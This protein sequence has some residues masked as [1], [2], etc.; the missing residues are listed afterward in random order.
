M[1][2]HAITCKD[3]ENCLPDFSHGA[4]VLKVF[5]FTFVCSQCMLLNYHQ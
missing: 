4:K 5:K 2:T 1:A 3:L